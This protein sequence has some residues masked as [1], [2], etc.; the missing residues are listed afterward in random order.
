MCV[1][2]SVSVSVCCGGVEGRKKSGSVIHIP[3]SSVSWFTQ[4]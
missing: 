4:V 3:K 1:C 2:V